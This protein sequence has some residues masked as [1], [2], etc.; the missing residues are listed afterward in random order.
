[1]TLS[2]I[3]PAD[4]PPS[5]LRLP[6]TAFKDDFN[7]LASRARCTRNLFGRVGCDQVPSA[8][9]IRSEREFCSWPVRVMAASA[10]RG[11]I[12]TRDTSDRP[13]EDRA[14][15]DPDFTVR[16]SADSGLR[17][18][19]SARGQCTVHGARVHL[20]RAGSCKVIASQAGNADYKAAPNVSRSF[21]IVKATCSVPRVTGKRL[22][23]A[24][25]AI[26]ANRCR[27]ARCPMPPRA[28][29]R[30]AA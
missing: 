8:T 5:A 23:A 4:F 21:A 30:R 14:F 27:K 17:V 2:S 20:V 25:R 18:S 15:G 12:R 6:R 9:K 7:L 11:Y 29:P 3:V 13:L 1:V 19:F 24:K 28:R 22:A 16:A 10:D 26:A